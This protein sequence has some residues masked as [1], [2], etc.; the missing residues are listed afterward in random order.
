MVGALGDVFGDS[1]DRGVYVTFDG[2]KTWTKSLYVGVRSGASDVAMNPV[3]PNIVYAG[4]WQFRREPWTFTSGGTDD[5]LYKSTDGGRHFSKLTGNGLP[6]GET[7][8]I[9]LAIAPSDPKR[10]FALIEAKGGILWRTDDDGAS[11]KM[12]SDDTLVDQRPFYFSH[13]A[14]DPHDANHVYAVSEMLAESK[15][16]GKKFAEIASDVHVDYHAIWIAPN[17]AHR[18]IRVK[19]AASD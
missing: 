11:W 2:G 17:D 19:M 4:I 18:I 5:G 8:R 15:D 14:V 16:G 6:T 1:S 13:I 3:N 10:V 7:G 9:G 12:M